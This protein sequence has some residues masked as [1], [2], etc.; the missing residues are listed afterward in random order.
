MFLNV[1]LICDFVIIDSLPLWPWRRLQKTLW[2]WE[3]ETDRWIPSLQ[4]DFIEENTSSFVND[5]LK[6][7]YFKEESVATQMST[8]LSGF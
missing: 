2:G 7:F 8:H 1:L 3:V 4:S 6:G 5:R